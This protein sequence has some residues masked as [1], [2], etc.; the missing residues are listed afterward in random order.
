[1]KTRIRMNIK[2][3]AKGSVQ[4]D[5]TVDCELDEGENSK[6]VSIVLKEAV[7]DFESS[8]EELGY[9]IVKA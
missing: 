9:T 3:N 8:V 6:D 1:M 5:C 2:A 4:T 7:K